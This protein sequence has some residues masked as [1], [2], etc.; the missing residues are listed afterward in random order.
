VVEIPDDLLVAPLSAKNQALTSKTHDRLN[1]I[2]G[3]WRGQDSVSGRAEYKAVW[4]E[5]LEEK[6]HAGR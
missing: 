2:L 4:R 5:H 1:A 3:R 6:Y